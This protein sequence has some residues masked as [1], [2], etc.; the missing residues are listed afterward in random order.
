MKTGQLVLLFVLFAALVAKP[1]FASM[2]KFVLDAFF[3]FFFPL[4]ITE[5]N[6][7]LSCLLLSH[8]IIE[9]FWI[10][11]ALLYYPSGRYRV[12]YSPISTRA[13]KALL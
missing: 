4:D 2:F 11:S 13:C 10:A 7:A 5:K 12:G 6:L 9:T 1:K 8:T 3:F